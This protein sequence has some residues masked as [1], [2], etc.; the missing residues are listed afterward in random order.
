RPIARRD[1]GTI[2]YSVVG[3]P[4]PEEKVP[5]S[6]ISPRSISRVRIFEIAWGVTCRAS[7][8][9]ARETGSPRRATAS[10]AASWAPATRSSGPVGLTALILPRAG[11]PHGP[12]SPARQ[13]ESPCD[14]DPVPRPLDVTQQRWL[15]VAPRSTTP[16]R[17]RPRP[18]RTRHD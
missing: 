1:S 6:A 10:T 18:P 2:R 3:L 9:A 8:R 13:G 12:P 16:S 5:L 15:I 17:Y 14:V 11:I 4:G 7:A